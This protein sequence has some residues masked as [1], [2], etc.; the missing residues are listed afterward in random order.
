MAS[1]VFVFPSLYEGIGGAVI[2]AQAAGLPVICS[3]IEVFKEVMRDNKS[4]LF[5]ETSN[6]SDL[7]KKLLQVAESPAMRKTMREEA[8]KN[9]LQ[10]FQ[11]E[12]INYQ[13]LEYYKDLVLQEK[14]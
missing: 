1:D 12:K 13:V 4:T 8:R 7:G 14:V 3:D 10:N 6:S 9:F 11:L 5:F 2:E